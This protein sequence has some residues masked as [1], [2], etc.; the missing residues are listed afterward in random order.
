MATPETKRVSLVS[1]NLILE[2]KS[3]I[4]VEEPQFY[5][6]N[7]QILET[8]SDKEDVEQSPSKAKRTI[9]IR[10]LNEKLD[11]FELQ[12]SLTR[13]CC[14]FGE[15]LKVSAKRNIVMRGQA[16]IVFRKRNSAENAIKSL[17]ETEFFGKILVVQWARRD[18]DIVL[19]FNKQCR[20]IGK[21][22]LKTKNYL[23][24]KRYKLRLKKK[25][26]ER[27]THLESLNKTQYNNQEKLNLERPKSSEFL[28][29]GENNSQTQNKKFEESSSSSS[30]D[31]ESQSSSASSSL[32]KKAQAPKRMPLNQPHKTLLVL[33][34]PNKIGKSDLENL[35]GQFTG[36][37][38]VR[39][40]SAKK[41]AFIDY[42][43]D[44]QARDALWALKEYTFE[45]GSL[46]DL[47]FARK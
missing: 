47:N 1:L 19:P 9:Y 23:Q 13:L 5:F 38:G 46:I 42:S 25:E 39:F 16:F 11:V 22:R 35:F 6:D 20:R 10:N 45:D 4:K 12:D 30:T 17:N 7:T 43:D 18:D 24:S 28:T 44:F 33:N 36:F 31:S 15:V 29:P 3:K 40:I 32:I 41:L 21:P 8:L 34:L 14:Q 2:L 27:L 26:I 37:E